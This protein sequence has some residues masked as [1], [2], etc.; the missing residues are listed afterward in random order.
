MNKRELIEALADFDDDMIVRFVFNYGDHGRTM[1]APEVAEVVKGYVE[2]S[3][4]VDD[5][6]EVDEDQLTDP[7][8]A[9]EAILLRC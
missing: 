2:H 1:V 5:M 7:E 8:D 6:A 3:A 4:Y 9:E